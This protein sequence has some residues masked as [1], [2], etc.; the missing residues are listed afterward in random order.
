[1]S[2]RLLLLWLLLACSCV[3]SGA[4]KQEAWLEVRSPHFV[5]VTNSNEKQGRRIADQFERMRSVFHAA[6]PKLQIDPGT[7]VIILAVKDEK[8]FQALEPEAYLAK[9]SLKLGGLF[10]RAAD[11]NYVLMRLGAEGDHP[12]A[13]VYHEYTHLLLSKADWMPLWMSEGLAEFYQNTDITDKHAALGQVSAD[14]ILWLRQNRLLPLPTLFAVDHNSPYYHEENKG[15]IFYAESWALMHYLEIN[16]FKDKAERITKYGVLLA[17][18]VDAVSAAIRAFGDLEH[19]Q[20][21][22]EAYIRDGRYN[23]FTM[24]TTTEVDDSAFKVRPLTQTQTAALRADFLA[25]NERTADAQ[26]LLDRVLQDDP[27]NV[28][29]LETKGHLAL[30]QGHTDEARKW[31]GQAVQL[32]SQDY[33]AHYYFAAMSINSG[34][35][36]SVQSKIEDS[37]R[38]AI[39]L[40]P[41]FAPAFDALAIVLAT[42]RKN[43]EEAQMLALRAITL[44]PTNVAYRMNV[45]HILMMMENPESAIAV[46]KAAQKLAKTPEQTQMVADAL[47]RA[48]EYAEMQTKFREQGRVYR[49]EQNTTVE[50]LADS[51]PDVEV[52]R[53]KHRDFVPKGPHRFAVG[54]LK[55]VTC[56]NPEID[57]TLAASGKQISLHADNYFKVPYSAL[58]FEPA[59]DLNPCTDLEN[60]PAKVEYVESANPSIA[61]QIVSVELRK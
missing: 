11:K 41:A 40:N 2:R 36:A 49:T 16:D 47:M 56:R 10:L 38:A 19:L 33:L 34:G 25:Y 39:K 58:G 50:T 57:L 18:N 43:M 31:Y 42:Q 6:F 23:Y 21:D 48:Q 9:G 32:D 1:M 35:D 54:V 12:Y 4:E 5:V 45:A 22:L 51:H 53:L 59:K 8:D 20:S 17:Q 37:L 3:S 60:R 15:S 46:L 14:N 52:T 55:E 13:V 28:S 27:K 7:P 24:T 61:A 30:R 26:A 44:D 29:A